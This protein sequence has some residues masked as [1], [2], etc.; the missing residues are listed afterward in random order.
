MIIIA[1]REELEWDLSSKEW[2][3][4]SAKNRI[5][6]SKLPNNLKQGGQAADAS[7]AQLHVALRII[8]ISVAHI[9]RYLLACL[10]FPVFEF[11]GIANGK[12]TRSIRFPTFTEKGRRG[13]GGGRD[14]IGKLALFVADPQVSQLPLRFSPLSN[15]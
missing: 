6:V 14:F 3:N 11:R 10:N 1:W 12:K 5:F 8:C 15:N 9:H 13:E 4:Y 7:L 2:P